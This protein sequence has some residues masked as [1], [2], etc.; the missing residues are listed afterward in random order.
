MANRNDDDDDDERDDEKRSHRLTFKA[1]KGIKD[2]IQDLW[3]KMVTN[4]KPTATTTYESTFVATH[5]DDR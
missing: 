5:N 4:T 2:Q 3:T 1:F